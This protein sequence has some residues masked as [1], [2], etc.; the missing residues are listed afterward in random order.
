MDSTLYL[1][2]LE[3]T[4][5][6]SCGSSLIDEIIGENTKKRVSINFDRHNNIIVQQLLYEKFKA[7]E[8]I[9]LDQIEDMDEL[10]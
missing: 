10:I 5:N 9:N 7:M 2:N 8:C 3:S 4:G 6:S 1:L